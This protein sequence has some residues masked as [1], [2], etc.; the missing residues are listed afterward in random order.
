[1]KNRRIVMALTAMLA[2]TLMAG[3]TFS[4]TTP[5]A[6]DEFQPAQP[7]A[8]NAAPAA[9]ENSE[10]TTAPTTQPEKKPQGLFGDQWSFWLILLAGF[11]LMFWLSGRKR[12]KQEATR[13]E[14]LASMKKG[15]KVVSIG[16]IIGSVIEVRD[17]E[18][19]VKVDETNNVRMK[20]ARWA[21]RGVGEEAKT[22]G[23]EDK[24]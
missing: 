23:P 16:G 24:K 9:A 21:I 4:Q 22:Q 6:G 18:I 13:K 5:P 14:M 3:T 15:D 12:R 10:A 8:D 2:L 1:M 17:D 19:T 11:V 7:K 20:F